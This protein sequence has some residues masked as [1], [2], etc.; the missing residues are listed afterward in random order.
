MNVISEH[1]EDVRRLT[2][3]F[4]ASRDAHIVFRSCVGR[5]RHNARQGEKIGIRVG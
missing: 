3:H 1:T 5:V 2:S 4:T